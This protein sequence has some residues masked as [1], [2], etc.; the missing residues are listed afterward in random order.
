MHLRS[1]DILGRV[2]GHPTVDVCEP[3]EATNRREPPID[4]GRRKAS[5]LQ[6]SPV[7]LDVGSCRLQ[8]SQVG[9]LCPLEERPQV[10]AVG[11]E[12][13]AAVT[14]QKRP[15]GNV[16]LIDVEVLIDDGKRAGRGSRL[17]MGLPP[18]GGKT[19]TG[20]SSD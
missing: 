8:D 6:G 3:I 11:V 7:Q 13:P 5:F 9:V 2:G 14:G 18:S 20:P 19:M 12:R 1:P 10:V 15:C 17:S 4:G 16:G